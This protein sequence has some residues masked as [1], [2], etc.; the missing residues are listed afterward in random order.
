MKKVLMIILI[1]VLFT[2]CS[3]TKKVDQNKSNA[4]II[5]DEKQVTPW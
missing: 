3:D 1:G 2:G 5:G 4:P